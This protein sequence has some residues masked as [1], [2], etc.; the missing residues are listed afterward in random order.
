[1]KTEP[2]RVGTG[3]EPGPTHHRTCGFDCAR[4][5]LA[6]TRCPVGI[7]LRFAPAAPGGSESSSHRVRVTNGDPLFS[8]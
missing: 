4:S 2:N 1:M 7:C 6:A 3:I 5:S 8:D